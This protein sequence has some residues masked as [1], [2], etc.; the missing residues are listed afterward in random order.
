MEHGINGKRT[1]R[2]SNKKNIEQNTH[3]ETRNMDEE[4]TRGT[5]INVFTD[6]R[7]YLFVFSY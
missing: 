2:S 7:M 5:I 1:H 6:N 4:H 3:Q